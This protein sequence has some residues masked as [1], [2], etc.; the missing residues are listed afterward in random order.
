MTARKDTTY[1]ILGLLTTGHQT[2]YAIK[3]L[4]DQSLNHFWK[5][6]Y[7]QIY[8]ILKQLAANGLVTVE[9]TTEAGR[10]KKIYHITEKGKAALR[11]WLSEPACDLPTV[12]S[13]FLL[14]LFFGKHESISA[15]ITKIRQHEKALQKR[16]QTYRSIEISIQNDHA[17]ED[18]IYW[19]MTL[20]YGIYETKAAIKWCKDMLEKLEEFKKE[21]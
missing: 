3:Q 6:S 8:P 2:G 16:Y 5:I 1:A 7:G 18:Q 19:Q 14:K 21:A 17:S 9:E 20:E 15:T 12:K 13:D 4:M 10:G 11:H